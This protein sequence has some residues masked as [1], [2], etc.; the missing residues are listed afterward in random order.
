MMR[1]AVPVTDWLDACADTVAGASLLG[2][3]RRRSSQLGVIS[4]ARGTILQAARI[5]SL[6]AALLE[7]WTLAEATRQFEE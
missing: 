1:P 5:E 4:M 6:R 2:L 3:V 7:A